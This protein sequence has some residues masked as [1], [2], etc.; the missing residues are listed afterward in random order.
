MLKTKSSPSLEEKGK[1][2]LSETA[3]RDKITTCQECFKD[4]YL[5]PYGRLCQAT[6][7]PGPW[8]SPTAP[9]LQRQKRNL[10]P[11]QQTTF[12]RD[13]NP[14]AAKPEPEPSIPGS[15]FVLFHLFTPHTRPFDPCLPKRSF[16]LRK[17]ELGEPMGQVIFVCFSLFLHTVQTSSDSSRNTN[18]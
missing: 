12:L 9:E 8:R 14:T 1:G 2:R 6:S 7:N 13:H 3:N 5:C 11:D 10:K 15:L 17:Q 16:T 4:V 18:P